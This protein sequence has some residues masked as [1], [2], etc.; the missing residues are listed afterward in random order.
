MTSKPLMARF[1][2]LLTGAVLLVAGA[3]IGFS[4]G[5]SQTAQSG[6]RPLLAIVL[7][8]SPSMMA[9]SE[10][11]SRLELAVDCITTLAEAHPEADLALVTFGGD[12]LLDFPPSP[13]RNGFMDA[14]HAIQP[15]LAFFPG[16]DPAAGL[17][18]AQTLCGNRRHAV[19]VLLTDGEI[20]AADDRSQ[21][22]WAS[23]S[24]PLLWGIT[25][26][27]AA[28][29][30]PLGSSWYRD[31]DTGDI[32]LSQASAEPLSTLTGL[33]PCP[34]LRFDPQA[35]FSSWKEHITRLLETSAEQSAPPTAPNQTAMALLS[36]FAAVFII[37]AMVLPGPR[38]HTACLLCSA[39]ALL[40]G[41]R[42]EPSPLPDTSAVFSNAAAEHWKQAVTE[43]DMQTALRHVRQG[44]AL[45]REALRQNPFSEAARIN[46]QMLLVLEAGLSEPEKQDASKTTPPPTPDAESSD[47]FS[48]ADD[49]LGMAGE[50]GPPR[51]LPDTL[52]TAQ[53]QNGHN[54]VNG[55]NARTAHGSTDSWRSLVT[56]ERGMRPRPSGVK[57]W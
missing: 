18:L 57:P 54:A 35:P 44:L 45:C 52:K 6:E 15:S 24:I 26:L 14:L 55:Q 25:G 4:R 19:A 29:P 46:L 12:A 53:A 3:V 39:L 22:T 42:K 2:C 20:H 1:A 17:E 8:A 21:T 28:V 36:I 27:G 31:P 13:D 33:A 30:I 23:R 32:A 37:A 9:S 16:S 10:T 38:S 34:Q 40:A 43:K 56:R 5:F 48:E 50:P 7:D 49:A 51:N 11:K 41:C 47:A